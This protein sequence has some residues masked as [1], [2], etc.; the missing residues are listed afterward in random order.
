MPTSS[1]GGLIRMASAE[2]NWEISAEVAWLTILR[3]VPS[4]VVR[5]IKLHHH[6]QTRSEYV[7]QVVASV[8]QVGPLA[9]LGDEPGSS[10]VPARRRWMR[11]QA[12][13][14][15]VLQ[16]VDRVGDI[17]GAQSI[18]SASRL[19]RC[20]GRS[21]RRCPVHLPDPHEKFCVGAIC[22]LH[23]VGRSSASPRYHGYL[24]IVVQCGPREVQAGILLISITVHVSSQPR[25]DPVRIARSLSNPSLSSA[26]VL[27]PFS[28]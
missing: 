17:V 19:R 26:C 15:E 27:V 6:S 9:G 11:D 8:R 13:A 21:G 4:A 20:L 1:D 12:G 5:G 2:T 22:G 16:I 7:G 14:I 18:N 3:C 10:S 24:R 23:F 25:Y 28:P